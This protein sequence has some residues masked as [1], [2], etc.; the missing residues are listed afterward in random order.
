M[1][2]SIFSIM[3]KTR[4]HLEINM[5]RKTRVRKYVVLCL[6]LISATLSAAAKNVILMI[7]DGG[8]MN[9][10]TAASY[11]E[12]G[13]LGH[14]V[15]DKPVGKHNWVRLG[16]AT[17][18]Q[19]GEYNPEKTWSN[20]KHQLNG[21]TD[22]AAAATALN[23]GTRVPNGRINMTD[24]KVPL[25]TFAKT[26]VESGRSVGIV[27]DVPAAHATPAGVWG[28]NESR[29]NIPALF[30]E[31]AFDSPS[32]KVWIGAGNPWYDN[33]GKKRKRYKSGGYFPAEAD[34]NK[35]K[36][37]DNDGWF[38]TESREDVQ[39]IA[40]GEKEVGRLCVIPRVGETFQA[41][42]SGKGLE[43]L[44]ED[45][46][47]LTEC[48]KAALETLKKN[49]K[50][51]YLMIEGGA[52]D[53]AGHAN[54]R[55]R[56]VQQYV[57]FN[58]AVKE[59]V[60]WI[61]AN[62]SFDETLLIITADHET[63]GFWGAKGKFELIGNNGKGNMPTAAFNSGNHSNQLVPLFAIGADSQKFIELIDGCDKTAAEMYKPL[64]GWTGCYVEN[65]DVFK[66][67]T[68]SITGKISLQQ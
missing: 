23:T 39:A 20:F 22:S 54:N 2:D 30:K 64:I 33:D 61:E 68:Y 18:S 63:G 29:D 9:Q 27:T 48:S 35:L 56:L 24:K 5:L 58:H 55:D 11:Y 45:V 26:V 19:G 53:W 51:F 8:G 38:F 40:N 42:R 25:D 41:R 3:Q 34:W 49:D 67:L 15:Y 4:K 57:L 43:P 13:E 17:Y 6:L 50:G 10:N 60:A 59:V 21:Y 7:A 36:S 65:I 16:C 28:H 12:Y 44:L 1:Y 47:R 14:Q 62:S 52:I 32:L 31:I 37:N 66:T 46:P